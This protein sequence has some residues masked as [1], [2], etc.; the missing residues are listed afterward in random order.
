M[1]YKW[2]VQVQTFAKWNTS[3][4]RHKLMACNISNATVLHYQKT[5]QLEEQE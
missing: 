5:Q 4:D 2:L 3:G 1:L